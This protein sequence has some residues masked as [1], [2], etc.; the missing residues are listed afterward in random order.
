[1]TAAPDDLHGSFTPTDRRALRAV[2][3]QFFVN[4][5]L[6]ASFVPRLPEIR[7]RVDIS[8]ATVGLLLSAG[9]L[10]GFLASAA[11]GRVIGRLGTRRVILVFGSALALSLAVIGVAPVP[12][13]LLI[14]LMGMSAFDVLVDVAMNLQGS[15]LSARRHAPVMNRLH[16]LW[17]L[18]TLV[19]G[20]GAARLAAAEVPLTVHLLSASLLLL[21]A[22]GYVGR[23]VLRIDEEPGPTVGDESAVASSRAP[24]GRLGLLLFGAAGLFAIAMEDTSISWAA[25]RLSDDF[26]SSPGFA[27]LGYVA[28]TGG[29][30]VARFGGDWVLARVGPTRLAALA[31]TL[32]GAGLA[33]ATLG[34]R[35][36]S[37]I[38]GFAV[39]G[40]GLATLMPTLYDAAAQHPGRPGAGLGALTGGLRVGVFVIPF[41]VGALAG[42]DLGVGQAVAIITLPCAVAYLVA[43]RRLLP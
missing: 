35:S 17:S 38:V 19:G 40:V 20:V 24:V 14:G 37:A 3:V 12:A 25:F 31:A 22:I 18:G 4:G 41:A 23:G 2:G 26:G 8:I 36:G 5:A 15:W 7:D 29:M 32:S 34:D 1:M 27:A 39:A 6:F 28:V 16:G 10:A 43:A 11:V 21:A 13:I 42:T 9:G 30:T 33:V